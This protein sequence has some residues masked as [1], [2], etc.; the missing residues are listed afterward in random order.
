MIRRATRDAVIT[1]D[2]R[3][4]IMYNDNDSMDGF[5][6]SASATWV[7]RCAHGVL[8]DSRIGS[9]NIKI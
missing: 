7:R 8:V 3:L 9:G 2:A 4:H 5:A 6:E 1:R